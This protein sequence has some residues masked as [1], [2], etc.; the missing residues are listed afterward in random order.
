MHVTSNRSYNNEDSLQGA[1]YLAY[2]YV[3]NEYTVV[4][5]M[6]ASKGFADIVYILR[7][8]SKSAMVVELKRN[9][10]AEMALTQIKERWYFD[11]LAFIKLGRQHLHYY[12]K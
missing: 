8:R 12:K 1:I 3:L 5:E 11:S 2:I 6:T 7:D 9:R 10:T 4:K